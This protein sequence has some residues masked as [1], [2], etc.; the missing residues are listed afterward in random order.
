M[1]IAPSSDH[2]LLTSNLPFELI[3]R[4]FEFVF[5]CLVWECCTFQKIDENSFKYYNFKHFVDAVH[6]IIY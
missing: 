5:W 4:K 2:S 6:M 3:L 1:H